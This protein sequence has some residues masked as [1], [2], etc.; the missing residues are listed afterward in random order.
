[1]DELNPAEPTELVPSQDERTM[2]MLA[3][4]LGVMGFIGPLIIYAI[5]A[6]ESKFVAY[7]AMQSL[8]FQIAY[9]V[10]IFV[11]VMP[12]AIITCGLGYILLLPLVPAVIGGCIWMGVQANN[13]EWKGYP[14]I[15]HMG[16]P[17]SRGGG[18]G[19]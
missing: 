7:H 10:V 18:K 6:N 8:I 9:L 4:V 17:A 15:E 1:M 11:V 14:L 5:K 16:L 2:A 12:I 3:H 13:G 19:A